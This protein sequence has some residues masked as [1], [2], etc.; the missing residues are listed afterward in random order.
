VPMRQRKEIQEMPRRV[1]VAQAFLPVLIFVINPSINAAIWPDQLGPAHVISAS[2]ADPTVNPEIWKEYGLQAAERADYGSFRATAYRFKDTTGAFAAAQWLQASDPKTMTLGNY[3]I[4][5]TGKCPPAGQLKEWLAASKPTGL[6]RAAYPTLDTY[7]PSKNLISGSKRY[8]Y[9]PAALAQFEPRFPASAVAFDFST[10][11]QIAKYRTPKGE[12]TLAIFSYPTPTMARQQL[13]EFQK[14]P[15]AAAKRTGTLVAV[16]FTPDQTAESLL[17]QINYQGSVSMDQVPPLVLKPESAAKML[18]AI[19]S[20]AGVVVAF[21]ALS[22]LAFGL[23]RVLAR[24][25]GHLGAND[26]MITLH[27]ADK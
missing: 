7:L 27:L 1:N 6:S 26:A 25:F 22:G 23:I 2:P 8:I 10:E 4:G 20:L 5:C 11:G 16:V 19:I 9:G 15:G 3:V 24:K 14:I 21:C 18:L 17:S 13:T 12:A